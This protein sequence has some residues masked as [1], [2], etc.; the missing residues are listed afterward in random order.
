MVNMKNFKLQ[1]F[2]TALRITKIRTWNFHIKFNFHFTEIC[3]KNCISTFAKALNSTFIHIKQCIH[4]NMNIR[5]KI[6]HHY[7]KKHHELLKV[8]EGSGGPQKTT[9]TTD[10]TSITKQQPPFQRN[11]I[12][13]SH[14]CHVFFFVKKKFVMQT[15]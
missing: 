14:L 2:A 15:L 7:H 9:R 4:K 5:L 3:C 1:K 6:N 8:T 12:N 10:W 13:K 11:G